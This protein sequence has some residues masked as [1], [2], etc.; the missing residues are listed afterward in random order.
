MDVSV[1]LALRFL[2]SKDDLGPYFR[3][4]NLMMVEPRPWVSKKLREVVGLSK[5][6][7]FLLIILYHIVDPGVPAQTRATL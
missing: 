2:L 7:S 6:H 5:L 3:A 4:F 1:F